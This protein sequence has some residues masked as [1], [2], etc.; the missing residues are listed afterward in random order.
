[1]R[2]TSYVCLDCRRSVKAPAFAKPNWRKPKEHPSAASAPRCPGCAKPMHDLGHRFKAPRKD[3]EKQ[4]EKVRRLAAAG[5]TFHGY[6]RM[7]QTL[8]EVD[9]FL[10]DQTLGKPLQGTKRQSKRRRKGKLAK[11]LSGPTYGPSLPVM[12]PIP[13]PTPADLRKQMNSAIRRAR[14]G[15]GFNKPARKRA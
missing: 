1:V 10:N 4:W 13:R 14:A 15:I 5:F 3:D 9:A 8:A 6:R 2:S 11:T 7:P 12:P